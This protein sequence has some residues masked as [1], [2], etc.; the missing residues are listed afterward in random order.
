MMVRRG[1]G[2]S[3]RAT[4]F[5]RSGATAWRSKRTPRPRKNSSRWVVTR[6]S[7]T[8]GPWRPRPM[9][10]T[11]GRATS[12]ASKRVVSI[13]VALPEWLA[14]F[15][16]DKPTKR[17][18]QPVAFIH[19]DDITKTSFRTRNPLMKLHEYQAKELL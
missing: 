19:R 18:L 3:K 12:S 11:L 13:M 14:G 6:C 8:S 4:I 17:L 16:Q 15:E 2:D 7:K 10:L 1:A 9:G 5:S